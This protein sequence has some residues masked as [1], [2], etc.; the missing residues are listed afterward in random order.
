PNPLPISPEP[1]FRSE[2]TAGSTSA[3]CV[4]S[5]PLRGSS[6]IRLSSTTPET[7]LCVVSTMGASPVTITCWSTAPTRITSPRL[8]CCPTVNVIPFRT[9]VSKPGRVTVISYDPGGSSLTRNRPCSLVAVVRFNP[10]STLDAV[11]CAPGST[12]PEVSVTVPWNAA[13]VVWALLNDA[14]IIKI[15]KEYRRNPKLLRYGVLI[16]IAVLLGQDRRTIDV[17]RGVECV[18]RLRTA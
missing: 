1:V 7:E 6:V 16:L 8:A 2:T 17:Y 15:T 3:N 12:H 10:V 11:T 4:K 5:R 14:A 13:V 18:D 9:R